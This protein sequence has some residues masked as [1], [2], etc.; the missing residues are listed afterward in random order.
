MSSVKDLIVLKEP[1][2][3]R[4]GIGR[5][6]F[7]DRY[8]VFDYG[9]MPDLID[10]KGKALCMITSYFFEKLEESGI[11]THYLGL[12]EDN[13]IKRI[14]EVEEPS[15]VME[16]KLVRVL[17]PKGYDYSIF[18]LERSNFLIPLE[19]IYRNSLPEGSSVFRRLERG[20]ISHKDLGLDHYPKPNE[21]LEKPIIDFSTKLEDRDR[22]L[23]WDEAR[24][25][26][27]LSEDE[28]DEILHLT[29]RIDEIITREVE[30]AGLSNEDG[31]IEFAFDEKR[32]L[33]VVDAVGTPDECRFMLEGLHISK[34]IL[35]R[36]YRR[37]D[38]YR[39][40]EEAKGNPNWREMAGKPPR[41]PKDLIK[42][43]SD[44]YKACCNEI[45]GKRWFEVGSLRDVVRELRDLTSN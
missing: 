21:K 15:E 30:K 10:G 17:K 39:R 37:T 8:S 6:V 7:S 5:F 19:V 18:K 13:K 16:V 26:A 11:R 23:K 9:V 20:E 27:G 2:R 1:K 28:F 36:Y 24:E 14:D 3:D 40:I 45:T 25:I 43:V 22:Y 32:G 42:A 33:M 34:E 44:M 35:R 31:K 4:T 38:W 29:L 12:V 41:L